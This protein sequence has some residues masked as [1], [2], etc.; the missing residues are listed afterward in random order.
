M[1]RAPPRFTRNDTLFP[2]TTLFRSVGGIVF[3]WI[4][5]RGAA[6]FDIP[7]ITGHEEKVVLQSGRGEHRIDHGRRMTGPTFHRA[8]DFSPAA[9]HGIS[10]GK[11]AALEARLQ[12]VARGDIARPVGVFG[13][14]VMDALI[15][16]AKRENAEKQ[17]V[18]RLSD[19]PSFTARC[20]V[21]I[22]KRGDLLFVG[23]P[24]LQKSP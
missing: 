17:D 20:P 24:T 12:R 21:R 4:E 3:P 19:R 23:P 7:A 22:D 13:I 1:I 2:Y 5:E 10:D 18:F 15:V 9:Y 6:V 8:G 14:E 11:N 16:L